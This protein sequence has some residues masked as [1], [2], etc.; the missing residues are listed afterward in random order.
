MKKWILRSVAGLVLVLLVALVAL[1]F[2]LGAILKKGV[3]RVG[4]SATQ[5]DVKLKGAEVWLLAWRVELSQFVLGNP[6]GCKTPSALVVRNVA[7][8]FKPGTLFSD[9]LVIESIQVKDPVLTWEGG[10]K[11]NNLKRIE[12][13]LDDYIGS[14]STAPDSKAPP[15]SPAKPE[16]KLQVNDLEIIGGKLQIDSVFS[17]GRTIVVPI[18]EIH[19]EDLGTG[20]QGIT[21]VEVA[22]RALH[23]VLN[24]A[25]K[26]VVKTAGQAGKE[27]MSESKNAVKKIEDHLKGL[28]H[29]GN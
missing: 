28:L 5:V 6:P 14:S 27:A 13:N 12:K 11:E 17:S 9:K 24:D 23:A 1:A 22:Q 25:A 26:E 16:R 3:E 2:S 29:S 8:R 18:P 7:V 19:L 4:P 20:P 10:L 15:A 21:P